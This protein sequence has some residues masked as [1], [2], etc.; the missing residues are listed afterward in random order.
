MCGI[1][2]IHGPQDDSWIEAMNAAQYHRGPDD[3]AVYR[4]RPAG[5]ALAMRRL[6]I[7]DLAGGHQPMVSPDGRHVLVFNGE[8]FNSPDLRRALVAEGV[9][10]ATDHSDTETLLQLLIRDGKAALPRLNGMFAFA[11][12]DRAEGRLLLARDRMGIK[13]LF[14]TLAGGRFAFASELRSLLRLPVVGRAVDRQSLFHYL[15]LHYVPGRHTILDGIH[16]LEPGCLIDYRLAVG[17]ARIERW[18]RPAFR[19]AEDVPAAEW[20]DR[21]RAT[22]GEAVGRWSLSD[23]PTACSL[24]G[25]L[26]SSAIVGLLASA[27]QPVRTVSLGFRGAGEAAFDELPLARRVAERWG[28]RHT[29]IVLDPETLRRAL[30]TMV[31]A[32]GEPYGGGLPS[33]SVFE[34]MAREVKV[35]FTGTGGDELFGNYGKWIGLEGGRLR[36]HLR[37]RRPAAV[38]GALFERAF[39][40]R[41]YYGTEADKRAMLADGGAGLVSTS[42]MLHALFR[43]AAGPATR[44]RA[45]A[46]DLATQLP[47]EF[48]MMTDRFSMAHGLEARTPFLDNAMVDLALS[49]PARHRT[50]A[51]DLK[52]L[53]RRAVAPLLPPELVTAPKKGFVIPLGAWMRGPLRGLV[54][55]LLAA[56]RLRAQGLFRPDLYDRWA[57]PHLDGAADL[58]RPLWGLLMFQMWHAEVVD[59][60]P[61]EAPP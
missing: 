43:G 42:E 51:G 52:G 8:I 58:T 40:D 35:G 4:D 53:L 33:W 34:A 16:R 2:G 22:L 20:P 30:P 1:V 17:E 50:G 37:P 5:I 54:G 13:P 48:L 29:E 26:D 59:G 60:T 21:L 32:L 38:D 23:V 55:E 31:A 11:F 15:T 49:I 18:W 41:H 27:G 10:F 3:G 47:E 19:P 6:A 7:L 44:D 36:R 56:D 46:V 12:L 14:H 39:T 57:R 28:T 45:A 25:G 61:V 9:R 24:S